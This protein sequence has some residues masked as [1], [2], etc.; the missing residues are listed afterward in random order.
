MSKHPSN[1]TSP[2]RRSNGFPWAG[3]LVWLKRIVIFYSVLACLFLLLVFVL[4]AVTDA[5][6]A[7]HFG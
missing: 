1:S 2:G 7:P 3:M 5:D 6:I 4:L